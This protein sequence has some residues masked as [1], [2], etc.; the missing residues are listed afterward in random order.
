[1]TKPEYFRFNHAPTS[2]LALSYC[3]YRIGDMNVAMD[4]FAKLLNAPE[5]ADFSHGNVIGLNPS[6]D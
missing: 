5:P 3:L 4:R 2:L 6:H 1:M